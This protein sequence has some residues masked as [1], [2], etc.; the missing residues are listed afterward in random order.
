MYN[1]CTFMENFSND[2]MQILY[3]KINFED[4]I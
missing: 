1:Y 4:V 2:T 3:T